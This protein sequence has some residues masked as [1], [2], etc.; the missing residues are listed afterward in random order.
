[1]GSSPEIPLKSTAVALLFSVILGPLGL[2]YASFWGGILMISIGIVVLS[3]KFFFPSIIFWIACSVWAV[4]AVEMHN[5]KVVALLKDG[6]G[7]SH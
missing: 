4:G 6:T 7:H 5:K 1:M 3:S 2:L